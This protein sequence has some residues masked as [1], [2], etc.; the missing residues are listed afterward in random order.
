MTIVPLIIMIAMIVMILMMSKA[1]EILNS[2]Q[3]IT[4]NISV[5]NLHC[6]KNFT[7][8]VVTMRLLFL[9]M[10]QVVDYKVIN[11]PSD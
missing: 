1:K 9:V 2:M 4:L 6:V 10:M 7:H 5:K 11:T 8:G 3:T